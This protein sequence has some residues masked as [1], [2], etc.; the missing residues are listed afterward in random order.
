MPLFPHV[1]AWPVHLILPHFASK[2]HWL[3]SEYFEDPVS[4]SLPSPTFKNQYTSTN[5]RT[6][7]NNL[8]FYSRNK[9][10]TPTQLKIKTPKPSYKFIM[11]IFTITLASSELAWEATALIPSWEIRR[12][13]VTSKINILEAFF[14]DIIRVDARIADTCIQVPVNSMPPPHLHAR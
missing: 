13:K 6:K 9:A 12:I 11:V 8:T 10:T 4:Q 2:Q 1:L 14:V 5:L 7:C 3:N